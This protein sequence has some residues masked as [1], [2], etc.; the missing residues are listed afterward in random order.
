[1]TSCGLLELRKTVEPTI[2]RNITSKDAPTLICKANGIITPNTLWKGTV[3]ETTSS[4]L[5]C[6]A[7]R[8]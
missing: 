1:M 6:N 8:D 2:I 4:G 7:G 5:C 3:V